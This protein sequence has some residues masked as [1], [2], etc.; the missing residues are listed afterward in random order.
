MKTRDWE[1]I[2]S[3]AKQTAFTVCLNGFTVCGFY[4][5]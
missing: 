1:F 3:Y 5:N 2:R 4:I